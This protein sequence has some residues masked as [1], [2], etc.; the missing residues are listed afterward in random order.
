[1]KAA[2]E[3]GKHRDHIDQQDCR[4]ADRYRDDADRINHGALDL[5]FELERLFHVGGKT[6]ENR[7]QNAADFSRR[8]HV[9]VKIIKDF[10]MFAQGGGK[11]VPAF[12]VLF[13][14]FDSFSKG[15]V[16]RLLP[17]N[18]QRLDDRQPGVNHSG[19]LAGKDDD[20]FGFDATAKRRK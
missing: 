2:K 8:H 17:K 6:V 9:G 1:A 19:Q 18:L 7:I 12:N 14:F 15:R 20:I 10:W 5:T 11:R 4:Y 3:V 13:N 16:W